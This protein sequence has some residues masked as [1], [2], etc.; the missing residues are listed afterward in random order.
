M[1]NVILDE[2]PLDIKNP[3]DYGKY[4]TKESC[5]VSVLWMVYD[6]NKKIIVAKGSS[7]PCGFNHNKASIH[8]EQQAINYCRRNNKAKYV[9]YIWRY[10]KSGNIKP[11]YCCTQ[12]TKMAKKYNY[13]NSIFT[14]T[15]DNICPAVIDDPPLSL[16][17]QFDFNKI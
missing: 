7:R 9:I 15:K 4:I 6:R 10:G 1:N 3:F 11:M 12:C 13:T 8:A 5:N 2:L 17:Y 16:A 14:F